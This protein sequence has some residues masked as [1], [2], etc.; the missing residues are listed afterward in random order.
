MWP[1]EYKECI[2]ITQDT[3]QGKYCSLSKPV[4]PN[5]APNPFGLVEL[6]IFIYY[7]ILFLIIKDYLLFSKALKVGI[8]V[9]SLCSNND[10]AS[11]INFGIE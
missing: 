1:G 5:T 9:P 7:S 2:N 8:C 4:D 10:I 11:I 3:F 6:K